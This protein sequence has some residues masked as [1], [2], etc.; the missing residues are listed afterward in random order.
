MQGVIHS[1]P[2][3]TAKVD[4]LTG[5][6]G[7]TIICMLCYVPAYVCIH[8]LLEDLCNYMGIN[9]RQISFST[10]ICMGR[11]TVRQT[12]QGVDDMDEQIGYGMGWEDWGTMSLILVEGVIL[13]TEPEVTYVLEL[14]PRTTHYDITCNC[15]FM[16]HSFLERKKG[17]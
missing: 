11:G 2:T 4:T 12:M 8:V 6:D 17:G 10:L 14:R 9:G 16:N 5:E 1:L 3:V 7:K 15:E 13:I